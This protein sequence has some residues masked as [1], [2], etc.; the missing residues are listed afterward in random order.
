MGSSRS[1]SEVLHRGGLGFR[2]ASL[3]SST[4]AHGPKKKMNNQ[5]WELFRD[6]KVRLVNLVNR[7][8]LNGKEGFVYVDPSWP[9]S[10]QT[11]HYP[12]DRNKYAVRVY[13]DELEESPDRAWEF[14][15]DDASTSKEF[16]L[17]REN[18]ELIEGRLELT[19][20]RMA[21]GPPDTTGV[22]VD[23]ISAP[24][25][26]GWPNAVRS[27][28]ASQLRAMFEF[29]KAVSSFPRPADFV[30]DFNGDTA[31]VGVIGLGHKDAVQVREW[32]IKWVHNYMNHFFAH[33]NI[34]YLQLLNKILFF[35]FISPAGLS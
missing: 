34:L 2:I 13:A 30:F 7:P 10:Q 24:I 28:D 22:H 17:K 3:A 6:D 8:D 9:H 25:L 16:V 5:R 18:L 29:I 15:I 11:S 26:Q 27:G 31:L 32:K 33:E 19:Q 12:G 23:G 21:S 14:N 35:G 1:P 4:R 20:Q